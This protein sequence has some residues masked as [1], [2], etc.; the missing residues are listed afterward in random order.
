MYIGTLT[1]QDYQRQLPKV[2]VDVCD[3]LKNINLQALENGRHDITD[4]IFMNV[5]TPTSDAPENKKAE[6]HHRYIDVQLII[7][8][9]DGME[10][11]VEQP[12]LSQYEEYHEE[13]DYQ[14]TSVAITDKNWIEV[15]PQQFVVFFPY[16]P[17]KPCCNVNGKV[18]QLKKLVVK[19]PIELMA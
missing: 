2:L 11:G 10:Y 14:L 4:D 9:V 6:L 15:H 17:H 16:E 5:M 8:G 12:D 3:Y 13:D 19:V 18:A 1:R 7:D